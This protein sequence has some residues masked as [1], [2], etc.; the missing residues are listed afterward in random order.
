MLLDALKVV[1][2]ILQARSRA[3]G[4][5]LSDGLSDEQ[6]VIYAEQAFGIKLRS[7]PAVLDVFLLAIRAFRE[8]ARLRLVVV[9]PRGGGKTKLAAVLQAMAWRHYGYEWVNIGGSLS[10]ARLCFEYVRDAILDTP[11]LTRFAQQPIIQSSIKSVSG[12]KMIVCAASET[13][14]RGPHP[15]GPSG[16]GGQTLDEAGIMEDEI[17]MAA[18]GQ[19]TSADP[20]ALIELSTMAARQGGHFNDLVTDAATKGFQLRRYTAFDVAK[21]CPHDCATTCPVR[22][23]FAEDFYRESSVGRELVHR[24]YCGGRA[25]E[26]DGWIDVDEIAQHWRDNDRETFERELLGFG[27]KATGQIYDPVLLDDLSPE[28]L[29]LGADVDQHAR[30]FQALE[31][32]VG[33]DWGFSGQTAICYAVRLK[34]AAVIYRWDF[35]SATRFSLIRQNVLE[36]VFADRIAT[37]FCDAANPSDNEELDQQLRN[38]SDRIGRPQPAVHGVPFGEWKMYGIGEVRR[39]VEKGLIRFPRTFGLEP[40]AHWAPAMRYL[41]NYRADEHGKPIKKEDHG[42]DALLCAMLGWSSAWSGGGR[43]L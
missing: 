5:G 43:I 39:R 25:H 13:S 19:L 23:H 22:A 8:R 30:R 42:P 11:D 31:K 27:S 34:D 38:E 12:A 21:R 32:A 1:R 2:E 28:E 35:V 3:H 4:V 29:L 14:V 20:S 24:A 10:Q 41:K 18:R 6:A 26:V 15:R 33:I 36:R 9:G 16:G 17:V 40:V 7:V 37:V